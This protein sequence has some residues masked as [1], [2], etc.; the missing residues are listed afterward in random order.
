MKCSY[1]SKQYYRYNIY[2]FKRYQ[3]IFPFAYLNPILQKHGPTNLISNTT[4]VQG[5]SKCTK[6]CSLPPLEN[7]ADSHNL[8]IKMCF[9]NHIL[10]KQYSIFFQRA[11]TITDQTKRTIGGNMGYFLCYWTLYLSFLLRLIYHCLNS[12]INK[13][14]GQLAYRMPWEYWNNIGM[15]NWPFLHYLSW[16]IMTFINTPSQVIVSVKY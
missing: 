15:Y 4:K 2:Y 7:K 1:F 14:I 12:F 16:L 8:I 5:F 11:T 3:P 9:S 10:R 13:Y 6:N